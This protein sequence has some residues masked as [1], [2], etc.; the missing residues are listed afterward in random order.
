MQ[1]KAN[2]SS[3]TFWPVPLVRGAEHRADLE[4]L[5]YLGVAGEEGPEGV[6]LRHDAAHGPD[7][8]GGGVEGAGEKSL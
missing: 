8:D 3:I 6:E 1:L 4:D 2:N 7:V 5:V